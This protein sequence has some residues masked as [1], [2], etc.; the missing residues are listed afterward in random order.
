MNP[1]IDHL[2]RLVFW[3]EE[4][5][6]YVATVPGLPLVSAFGDS[7]DEA[8][9][10][11]AVALEGCRQLAESRGDPFPGPLPTS[12]IAQAAGLLNLS[13]L[14]RRLGVRQSTLASKIARGTAFTEEETRSVNQAL[15]ESGLAL[16][17]TT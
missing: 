4:D 15:R 2:P 12:S 9:E 5:D 11:L 3:S 1:K 6:A 7:E 10:E 14:A 8:R 13:E 17:P 16:V